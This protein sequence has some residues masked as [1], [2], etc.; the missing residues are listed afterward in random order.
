MN[1]N[2]INSDKVGSVLVVGGGIG[3]MQAALDLADSGFK[4]YLLEEKPAI[5]G[6]MAQLDKTFPTNECSMCIM[7]PKLVNVG[8]HPNI[9]L[10]TYAKL[11]N[12][13]GSSGNFKVKIKKKKSYVNFDKCTGC[14]ECE[15]VCPVVLSSELDKC[16]SK[17]HAIYKMYPQAIPNVYTIDKLDGK[18]PCKMACPANVNS[19]GYVQ[20]ISKKKFKE[21]LDLIRE[22]NPFPT[23]CGRVCHH[24]CE[25]EC[26][27]SKIDQPIAIRNLKR[28][29][30]D[31]ILK[32]GE[33]PPEV[34]KHTKKE[35]IAVIGAGPSGLTCAL[36]LTKMGY[37]VTIFE[38]SN[39]PGGMITSCIPNYRIPE[40][41]ATYDIDRILDYGIEIRKNV[42]IGKDLTLNEI[43]KTYSAIYIA[44]GLQNPTKLKIDGLNAKGI[45]YGI[46]FLRDAKNGIKPKNFGK[47]IIIIGGGNVAIDCAKTAIRLGGK[48]V[49]ILY[50]RTKKEMT[51]YIH[52]IEEAVKEG[53]IINDSLSLKRIISKN[54]KITGIETINSKNLNNS[55]GNSKMK[56]TSEPTSFMECDTVI[57]AIGQT[58]DLTGFE[59]LDITNRKTIETDDIT[60]ETNIPGVFAG[61]DIVTGPASVI[62]AIRYGS[63]AAIS[64]DR[65]I[66][67]YDLRS[68][69]GK[70]EKILKDLREVR[71]KEPRINM[72]ITPVKN[73]IHDF[74][75][76]KLGYT[77]KQAVKEANRCLS[78]S[79]CSECMQCV[80]ACEAEAIDFNMR[81][82]ILELNVGSVILAPGY[83]LFD[84]SLRSEYGYSRYRNVLNSLEFECILSA[85]GPYQGHVIRPSDKK[86]PKKIAWIQ[87]VGSRDNVHGSNYC[88][89][90][91]CIYAIKEAVMVKEHA[92][93]IEPTIFFIDMRTFSKGFERY[94]NRAEEEHGVRFIR[95]RISSIT[96]EAQT[97]NLLIKYETEDGWLKEEEFDM[98][99]LSV[100]L[101]A[102]RGMKELSE[103]IGVKLNAFSFCDITEFNPLDTTRQGVFVCGSFSGPKDIPET[104]TEGSAAAAKAS[105]I[106]ASKRDTL[107]E[108]KKFPTE[109]DIS[110]ADPRIG[111]F[112]CNCGINIGN[113]I[114]IP[115][116]VKYANKLPNVKY[117]EQNLYTCSEDTQ[118]GIIEKIK[119][120]KLNRVVVASCTPRT[121]EQLFQATIREAGLNPHL[122]EMANI[123]DQ[124]SWVHMDDPKGATQKAKDLVR[125]AVSKAALLEPISTIE[126]DVI[127][128][129]LVIGGGLAG[130]LSALTIADQGFEVFLIE[131]EKDLGG[132]LKNIYHTLEGL[133]VQ[134]YMKSLINKVENHPKIRLYK[135]VKIDK[136]EGYVGNYVTTVKGNKFKFTVNHGVII[137]ATGAKE[138]QPHEYIY[139]KDGRV[140]TQLE[141]EKKLEKGQNFNKKIIVMIQCVGSRDDKHPY[142]SRICCSDAI[143]NALK[144]KEKYNNSE[145]YI[146]YRDIRTY[147]FKETYYEKAREKGII[148]IRYDKEHKPK[149]RKGIKDIEIKVKETI[150]NEMLNIHADFVVLSTGIVPRKENFE[151]AKKLKVPLNEDNFF[152]EAHIKLRPVDF[153]HEGIFLA[154]LS[155]S[156]RSIGETIVQAYAAA[157][158]ALTVISKDKYY[159]DVPIAIIDEDLCSGCG[160]C[161]NNCPYNAIEIVSMI[162]G[163]KG[164]KIV[165]IIEGA[166]KGC[167]NCTSAC[168]SGAIEQKGFKYNQIS[169]MI[170][171]TAT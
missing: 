9:E 2:S 142:C 36:K 40:K 58:P 101:I 42:K 149:V 25:E 123:R 14:G 69:R 119:K 165:K 1:S 48:K 129:A 74:R 93:N 44:I 100:G 115:S 105:N 8:R 140:I 27:R 96:E 130:M 24:P 16:L 88:S 10:I 164:K 7:S 78:C 87:C 49:T 83:D 151:I 170:N 86:V 145:I 161:I 33:D 103:K 59:D 143:K 50:R 117:V 125:M 126:L 70:K 139:G 3:G 4:I 80:E 99:I 56:Q 52:K 156:P 5:G 46:P 53:A 51:A 18:S 109:I 92:P 158:R 116:V 81:E 41:I 147:S 121:H 61:G 113:Y 106:I 131:R 120:N 95:S 169:S 20:L 11:E 32:H 97:G 71:E 19:Q 77:E 67:K 102:K 127:N 132:N 162:G 75:E 12:I 62:E 73:R 91:C 122:F 94:Y 79:I 84:A 65:Y 76:I 159:I 136:C 55:R 66:K 21:A 148:F 64:I 111:I 160:L 38:E 154:G 163:E 26:L 167:G 110:R 137:V 108:K 17:R 135:N 124:C 98:V 35:K 157:S 144:I 152:L 72:R 141:L 37:P 29:A 47:Q 28:F 90:V 133:D 31:Y 153:T 118:V 6:V 107:I 23:I 155:H 134:K 114:D 89:S 168:P 85:S 30:S 45:I 150:L 43:R 63:E 82:K 171:A 54:E 39:K 13:S 146:L 128:K 104:V 57:I 22:N 166:C 34:L 15:Q 138:Y 68:C 60:L 112:I